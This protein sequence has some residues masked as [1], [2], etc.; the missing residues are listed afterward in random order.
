MLV[1]SD[2]STTGALDSDTFGGGKI[3]VSIGSGCQ[4]TA[5]TI[6]KQCAAHRCDG[7]R[8]EWHHNLVITLD[9]DTQR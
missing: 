4:R 8:C 1:I 7:N 3:T 6:D 9:N 2:L 5:W